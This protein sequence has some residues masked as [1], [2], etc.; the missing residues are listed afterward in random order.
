MRLAGCKASYRHVVKCASQPRVLIRSLQT[1]SNQGY[2]GPSA[3][4]LSD[5]YN[6]DL[7]PANP[8]ARE[9]A[10]LG[11]GLTG[12]ATA[13]Y[14]NR[15]LPKAKITIYEKSK[16]LGGWVDSELVKVDDGEVL[17]EWGPRTIRSGRKPAPMT[18]IELVGVYWPS[19]PVCLAE[20]A[21]S[22]GL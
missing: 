20:H 7:P 5:H 21:M 13:F 11:G 17:F 22:I 19:S 14:L 4:A 9:I 1:S 3:N 8:H 12:L 10:I 18:M 2:G 6:F 15:E 16:R